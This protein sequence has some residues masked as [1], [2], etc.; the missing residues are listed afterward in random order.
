MEIE[1]N[2][3]GA[4]EWSSLPTLNIPAIK[5]QFNINAAISSLRAINIQTRNQDGETWVKYTV[6]PLQHNLST[7]IHCESKVVDQQ[8]IKGQTRY[9]IE[10]QVDIQGHSHS[11]KLAL[12]NQDDNIFR[13][14]LN[15]DVLEN[16]LID[17][18]RKC[19]L[20][21]KTPTEIKEIYGNSSSQ[22]NSLKIGLLA[23]NPQLYS[24]KRLVYAAQERGHDIEFI[25]ID[26]CHFEMSSSTSEIHHLGK[27]LSHLDAII[28][29]IRPSLT[30]YGCALTRQFESLGVFALN[31]ST[32]IANSRDKLMSLQIMTQNGLPIPT[33]AFSQSSYNNQQ[34]MRA[35]GGAPL[36]IKLISGTQGQG[37]ILADSNKS[38]E[39]IMES[40]RAVK[41]PFLVQN[42]IKESNGRDVR[43]F[44]IDGKVVAAMERIAAPGEFRANVHKGAQVRKVTLSETDRQIAIQAAKAFR[45][46]VAGVDLIQSN[47]G[48][49]VLE[50]NSSPGLEGIEEASGKDIANAMIKAIEN[51]LN[52]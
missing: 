38:A 31:K 19:V 6:H 48:S 49:M 23:T 36:I 29:R 51:R 13:L 50:V 26:H 11:I 8:Q 41:T 35:V 30:F 39:S 14:T 44:V 20:G 7:K 43:V 22:K 10:T 15:K 5:S 3:F 17:P 21:K 46:H 4:E 9:I 12:L 16:T 34:V 45:L 24:A 32:A 42:F 37:V 47:S 40:F 27:S 28:P 52:Q 2:I 25:N 33:T 18:L 1:K